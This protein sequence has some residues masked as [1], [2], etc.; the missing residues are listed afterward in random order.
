M[1]LLIVS[2]STNKIGATN[3]NNEFTMT[4]NECIDAE[5]KNMYIRVLNVSYPC[6]I[7]N[8]L[9]KDCHFQL[10]IKFLNFKHGNPCE[11][12][13]DTGIV[14]I[15]SGFYT[16]GALIDIL[17]NY[18]EEYDVTFEKTKYGKVAVHYAFQYEHWYIQSQSNTGLSFDQRELNVFQKSDMALSMELGIQ[19]SEKLKYMLGFEEYQT[20]NYRTFF[21]SKL[22]DIMDGVNKI[23]IYCDQVEASVVGD[24]KSRLLVVVP[25]DVSRQGTGQLFSYA[26]SDTKKKLIKAK[27]PNFKLTLCDSSSRLIPFDAGSVSIECLLEEV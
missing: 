10:R 14:H 7:K 16:L 19:F 18:L 4:L 5:N 23:F 21:G 1:N 3:Y 20:V 13:F 22:P 12:T 8:V 6:T 15:P 9:D 2:D 26:P 24:T 17:N 25:I 27:I 11:I